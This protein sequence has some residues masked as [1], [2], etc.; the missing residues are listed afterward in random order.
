MH[1]SKEKPCN[2]MQS[3]MER[4]HTELLDTKPRIRSDFILPLFTPQYD[5]PIWMWMSS[6]HWC[7]GYPFAPLPMQEW[8]HYNPWY[9]SEY[10]C[11]YHIRKWSSRIEGDFPPFPLPYI[12]MNGYC[13]SLEMI[14]RPWQMFTRPKL[15]TKPKGGSLS[16]TQRKKKLGH[17]P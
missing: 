8:A 13:H 4:R 15:L 16:K 6:Y 7:F 11:N 1:N 3:I 5:A 2:S 10:C 17:V 12:E 9:A 14:F